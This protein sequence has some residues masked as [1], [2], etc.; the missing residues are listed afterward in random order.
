[1]KRTEIGTVTMQ[2]SETGK[3]VS[4][5]FKPT[6]KIELSDEVKSNLEK[7]ISKPEESDILKFNADFVLGTFFAKMTEI[8]LADREK[9][10]IVSEVVTCTKY[11]SEQTRLCVL[12]YYFQDKLQVTAQA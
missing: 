1:M 3:L 9:Q 12:K 6:L 4:A 8:E 2:Y 11:P 5:I 7:N 10:E